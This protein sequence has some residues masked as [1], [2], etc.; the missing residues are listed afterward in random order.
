[1]WASDVVAA[2]RAFEDGSESALKDEKARCDEHLQML[3]E[4]IRC[5][6][7]RSDRTKLMNVITYEVHGR[8]TVAD[9]VSNRVDSDSSFAWQQQLRH[10]YDDRTKDVFS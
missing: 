1:M 3:A 4:A 2:F 7:S 8:D 10:R 6:L 9:L 5:E